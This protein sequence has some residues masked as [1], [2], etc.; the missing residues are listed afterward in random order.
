MA[1]EEARSAQGPVSIC[2]RAVMQHG[3]VRSGC[4]L[5]GAPS[6]RWRSG[7]DIDEGDAVVAS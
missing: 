4:F 2:A 7:G 6:P 1:V 5:T 3:G